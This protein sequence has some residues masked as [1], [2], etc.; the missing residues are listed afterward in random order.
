LIEEIFMRKELETDYEE[1]DVRR[2][3][4]L[5]RYDEFDAYISYGGPGSALLEGTDWEERFFYLVYDIISHN[6]EHQEKIYF[7]GICHSFQL[8]VQ[9]F[10]LAKITKRR[11]TSFGVM[12][13]HQVVEDEPLFRG[14]ENPFWV[15]DSRDYQVIQPNEA[16]FLSTGAKILCLEKE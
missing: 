12:P 15:V 16:A 13:T 4:V 14:L 9:H 10:G 3:D 2:G 1:L 11:S 8:L 6:N 5:P 7:F